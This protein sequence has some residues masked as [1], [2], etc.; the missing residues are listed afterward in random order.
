VTW[1]ERLTKFGDGARLS[2]PAA[3]A[4]LAAAERELGLAMPAEL[5]ALL[6]ETDGVA[7]RYGAQVVWPAS[8]ISRQN[9]EFRSRPEFRALYMPFDALLFFG[10]R[11][12][13]DQYFYRVLAGAVRD[14]DVF[15][16]DHETDS[17]V[18]YA[19]SLAPFLEATLAEASED[20]G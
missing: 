18:W 4:A 13:G 2:P 20:D 10:E 6:A 14:P 9:Q 19:P 7:D 17:R 12:N 8:L 11:G 1:R 15:R 5:R 3:Q 16:W